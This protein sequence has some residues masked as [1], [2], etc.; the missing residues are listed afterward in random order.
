ML[1]VLGWGGLA[2]RAEGVGK[3]V[4]NVMTPSYHTHSMLSLAQHH[5]KEA[6]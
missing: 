5:P 6:P 3:T 4:A 2:S 1:L